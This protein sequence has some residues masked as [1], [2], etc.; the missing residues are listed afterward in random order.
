MNKKPEVLGSDEKIE[1]IKSIYR[2][3]LMR[4]PDPVGLETYSKASLS[5]EEIV[6][7]L[8]SSTEYKD[9]FQDFEERFETGSLDKVIIF[10]AYGNGNLGDA[11]QAKFL[12]ASLSE[13]LSGY[14]VWS[15]SVLPDYY[16]YNQDFKA[17]IWLM[18]HKK[19]INKF[20]ALIIGGGGL[21]S[22]PHDPLLDREWVES[23]EIPIYIFGVGATR[24][25]VEKSRFLIE[26]CEFVSARDSISY[27][28]LS[29]LRNDVTIIRDPVL[30]QA[31]MMENSYASPGKIA[32]VLKGPLNEEHYFIRKQIRESD[33][34]LCFEPKVDRAIEGLFPE[35]IYLP[36]AE[37]FY[38]IVRDFSCVVTSRYH[39]AILAL[40]AGKKTIAFGDQKLKTLFHELEHPQ[41]YLENIK[42]IDYGLEIS[43]PCVYK[44]LIEWRADFSKALV[45]ITNKIMV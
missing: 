7:V 39:G 32:W 12:G 35:L 21:L 11:I 38:S 27:A 5:K 14:D 36:S 30:C 33:I 29:E 26:K 41:L 2:D 28:A 15:A 44:R 18:N 22:H 43:F 8:K 3:V 37:S 16:H 4:D 17:P 20:K 1:M 24:N 9:K 34:V 42:E 19:Y 40:L 31:A 10:G 13:R 25:I 23:I 6:K 45:K